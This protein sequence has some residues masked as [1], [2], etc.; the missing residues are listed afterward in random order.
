MENMDDARSLS[1]FLSFF[2]NLTLK[3]FLINILLQKYHKQYFC[4]LIRLLNP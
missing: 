4:N 2:L 3:T 1:M